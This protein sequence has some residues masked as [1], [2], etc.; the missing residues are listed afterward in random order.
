MNEL[1]CFEG[2]KSELG[3]SIEPR[4]TCLEPTIPWFAAICERVG[5]YETRN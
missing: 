5:K 1:T 2:W 4:I 3:L